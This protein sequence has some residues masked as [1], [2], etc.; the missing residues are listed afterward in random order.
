MLKKTEREREKKKGV[1]EEKKE[2]KKGGGGGGGDY[3]S[4][5]SPIKSIDRLINQQTD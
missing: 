5:F 3:G 4:T 2:E 1:K